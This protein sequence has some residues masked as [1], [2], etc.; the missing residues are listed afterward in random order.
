MNEEDAIAGLQEV[1]R[2]YGLSIEELQGL[3]MDVQKAQGGGEEMPEGEEAPEGEE[4]PMPEEG[5]EPMP[6]EGEYPEEG[7]VDDEAMQQGVGAFGDARHISNEDGHIPLDEEEGGQQY[8]FGGRMNSTGG[9]FQGGARRVQGPVN[10]GNTPNRQPQ[11]REER[12]TR[13]YY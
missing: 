5:E 2:K 3:L 1:A 10:G 11:V 4:E 6:E 7:E 13:K 9:K 12:V 8:G